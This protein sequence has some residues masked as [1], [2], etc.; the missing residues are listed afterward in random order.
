[1]VI[2][3]GLVGIYAGP[4]I[5]LTKVNAYHALKG[6]APTAQVYDAPASESEIPNNE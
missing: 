4:Y 2:T 6:N 1:M 3:F 5:A